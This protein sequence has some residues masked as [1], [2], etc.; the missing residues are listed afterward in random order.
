M[1]KTKS[2]RGRQEARTGLRM[3]VLGVLYAALY[4]ILGSEA[5]E[6]L[7]V[8]LGGAT[9]ILAFWAIVDPQWFLGVI[10]SPLHKYLGNK[11]YDIFAATT[12][13]EDD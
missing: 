9:A 10:I 8:L 11:Y 12:R 4:W 5:M 3:I 13:T 1:P 2:R 6:G 7:L